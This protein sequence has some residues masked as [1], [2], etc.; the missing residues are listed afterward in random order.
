[1]SVN[2]FSAPVVDPDKCIICLENL[3]SET[4][5]ELPE[6]SHKFQQNCII[7]WFRGGNCKCPLC[8]NLGVNDNTTVSN[9]RGG[10]WWTGGK[11]KYQR[12]RQF[13]R[14][15][16]APPELKKEIKKLKKLEG[17]QKDL[18]MEIKNFKTKSGMW[19]EL[20]KEWTK[21]RRKRWKIAATIRRRKMALASFNIVPIIIA[22]KVVV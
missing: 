6:C 11:Y 15:K 1:M 18:R 22:K 8:N 2:P 13:S 19:R 17:K 3:S 9:G 14:K 16:E 7:H 12:I 20:D 10:W 4:Q 5:Y 21:L